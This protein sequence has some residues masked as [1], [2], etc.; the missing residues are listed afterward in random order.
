MSRDGVTGQQI[1]GY[2]T[3]RSAYFSG[4]AVKKGLNAGIGGWWVRNQGLRASE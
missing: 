4:W 3:P 1:T 2:F